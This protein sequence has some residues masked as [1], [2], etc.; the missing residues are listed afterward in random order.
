MSH[1]SNKQVIQKTFITGPT[2]CIYI[3]IYMYSLMSSS[4]HHSNTSSGSYTCI[5]CSLFFLKTRY[6]KIYRFWLKNSKW[7]PLFSMTRVCVCV[8][9]ICLYYL[10]CIISQFGRNTLIT[11]VW[12][13]VLEILRLV[14]CI[15]KTAD[16]PR[17]RQTRG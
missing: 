16:V 10:R 17:R 4:L 1:W 5:Y 6:N 2:S 11:V 7:L 14:H 9:S 13:D 12:G 8:D 15:N 3:Y